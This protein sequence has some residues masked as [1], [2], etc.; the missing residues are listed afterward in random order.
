MQSELVPLL[1]VAVCGMAAAG[2]V[3]PLAKAVPARMDR[4]WRH[5]M[6][7]QG[8]GGLLEGPVAFP[9]F[10]SL[11]VIL[12]GM[13]L[14][15]IAMMAYGP[16]REGFATSFFLVSLLLLATINVKTALL[17]DMVVHPVL[18]VGL[19]YHATYGDAANSIYGAAASFAVPFAV[20]IVGRA[21]TGKQLIGHGDMKTFA[22]VGAWLGPA[23]LP[24]VVAGFIAGVVL[25][26]V[27]ARV[28]ARG[29]PTVLPTGPSY[30]IAA[31]TSIVW[32][33]L[34]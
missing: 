12:L 19:L 11:L 24:Q 10:Q 8:D 31:M 34:L 1:S 18:W 3:L 6:L 32:T 14:G 17:P 15:G 13:A 29:T 27:L 16:T 28:L 9:A 2:V 21:M 5:D 22:V 4:Q 33:R 26:A 30:V 20:Y 7:S 23:A 25:N